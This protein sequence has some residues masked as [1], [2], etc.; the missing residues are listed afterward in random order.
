[1]K[2]S[3]QFSANWIL[4]WV[5]YVFCTR[6]SSFSLW[7][8][9]SPKRD[10]PQLPFVYKDKDPDVFFH[11]FLF[12]KSIKQKNMNRRNMCSMVS[13]TQEIL[14]PHK[15]NTSAY[16]RNKGESSFRFEKEF[17]FVSGFCLLQ[18]SLVKS[19]V[20]K[21][22][23]NYV[24]RFLNVKARLIFQLQCCGEVLCKFMKQ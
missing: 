1:M 17:Q 18:T 14:Q 20:G 24:K 7:K 3:V 21:D 5:L 16:L 4:W 6:A 19:Y 13:D 22:K 12:E 2:F 9:I 10:Y 11:T 15:C 8:R 23:V